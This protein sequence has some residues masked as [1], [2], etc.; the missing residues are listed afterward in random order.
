MKTADLPKLTPPEFEI[1]D[2]VWR[3]GDATVTAILTAVNTG[4]GKQLK[5]STIQVQVLRL[6]EKGWLTHREDGKRFFFSATVPK[7]A[8]SA[9]IVR[10][11]KERVFGGSCAELVRAMFDHTEVSAAEIQKLRALIDQYEE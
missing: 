11:V 4:G 10:D 2:V 3:L 5:R 9:E 7:A 1:M 8:V 6:E